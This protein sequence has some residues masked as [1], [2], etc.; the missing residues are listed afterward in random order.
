MGLSL[1]PIGGCLLLDSISKN[2]SHV[3]ASEDVK[4]NEC[5]VWLDKQ[6][7]SSVIYV[8]FGSIVNLT[9]VDVEELAIGLEASGHAFLWALRW[10]GKAI[11]AVN[12]LVERTKGRGM[13]AHFLVHMRCSYSSSPVFLHRKYAAKALNSSLKPCFRVQAN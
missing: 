11:E 6:A 13:R 7:T 9:T 1:R 5:L 10:E 12:G 4:K 3:L 2:A 8:A